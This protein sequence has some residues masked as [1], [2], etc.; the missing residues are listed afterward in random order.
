MLERLA[1]PAFGVRFSTTYASPCSAQNTRFSGLSPSSFT[2]YMSGFSRGDVR[3]GV[4]P[5][6][7]RRDQRLGH[8][9]DRAHHVAALILGLERMAFAFEVAD[10]GVIPY[11]HEQVAQ[12]RHFLKEADVAGV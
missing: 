7:P 5:A 4:H 9:A 12:L 6:V 10:V 11:R 3:F 1:N 8:V 2:A